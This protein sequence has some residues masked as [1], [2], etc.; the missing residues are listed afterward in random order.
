MRMAEERHCFTA[1]RNAAFSKREVLNPQVCVT[2]ERGQIVGALGSKLDSQHCDCQML[3]STAEEYLTSP[4]WSGINCKLWVC[5]KI[6][7][8]QPDSPLPSQA[9]PSLLAP[10]LKPQTVKPFLAPH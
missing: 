4:I 1:Q 5:F 9:E 10:S 7:T 8:A 6:T 2:N 3:L